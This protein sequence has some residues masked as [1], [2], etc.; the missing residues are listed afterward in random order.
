MRIRIFARS[1]FEARMGTSRE[2]ALL[3]RF[4]IISIN[5]LHPR[6]TPPFSKGYR[7][8]KNILVLSFDDVEYSCRNAI[9]A[10]DADQILRFALTDDC[11]PLL[12]HCTAGE[13][14]SGA[15]GLFLNRLLNRGALAQDDFRQFAMDYLWVAETANNYVYQMLEEA[16]ARR[17]LGKLSDRNLV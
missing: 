7:V 13:S 17:L 5:S 9:T 4:R 14:R 16:H 2:P 6:E 8:G 11:R 10:N 1:F 15:V 12:I 3:A